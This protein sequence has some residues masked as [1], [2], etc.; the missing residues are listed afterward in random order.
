VI[1]LELLVVNEIRLDLTVEHGYFIVQL[2]FFLVQVL[3][4]ASHLYYFSLKLWVL[5]PAN[6]FDCILVQFLNIIDSFQDVCNV[7]NAPFLNS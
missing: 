4:L 3:Q 7:I 2:F 6:P 1:L 5:F